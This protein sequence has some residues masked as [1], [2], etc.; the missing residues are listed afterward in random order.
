[1]CKIKKTMI[2]KLPNII[3]SI[4]CFLIQGL[5]HCQLKRGNAKIRLRSLSMVDAT[6]SQWNGKKLYI[7]KRDMR[8]RLCANTYDRIKYKKNN[9]KTQHIDAIYNKQKVVTPHI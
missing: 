7:V 3:I 1:M 4:K 6:S 5:Y 8:M 9:I 2:G